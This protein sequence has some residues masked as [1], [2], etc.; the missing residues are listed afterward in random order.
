MFGHL[1]M[2]YLHNLGPSGIFNRGTFYFRVAEWKQ[3]E[4][5]EKCYSIA[6]KSVFY[7]YSKYGE[8]NFQADE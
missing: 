6:E 2:E 8:A 3:D 5:A 7:Y 1:N 4:M